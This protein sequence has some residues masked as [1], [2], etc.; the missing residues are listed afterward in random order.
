MAAKEIQN[1]TPPTTTVEGETTTIGVEQTE[2]RFSWKT[3]GAVIAVAAPTSLLGIPFSMTLLRQGGG[4]EIPLWALVVD[5]LIQ[6]IVF[7]AIAAGL[8]LW[9]GPKVGLGAL[10]LRGVLHGEAGSGRRV[11]SALP[12]AAGLGLGLGVVGLAL[13]GDAQEQ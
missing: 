2:R 3:L 1:A 7:A 9:L 8:G 4:P 5:A 12:L 10:D 11:L 6:G 13:E